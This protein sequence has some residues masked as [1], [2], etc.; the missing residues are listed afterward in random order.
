M[1]KASV[2]L[3]ASGGI[4]EDGKMGSTVGRWKLRMK[5]MCGKKV[6]EQRADEE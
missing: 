4:S 3:E 1:D 2:F 6:K 5:V